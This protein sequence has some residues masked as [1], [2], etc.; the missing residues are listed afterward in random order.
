MVGDDSMYESFDNFQ[1]IIAQSQFIEDWTYDPVTSQSVYYAQIDVDTFSLEYAWGVD[2]TV[3][4]VDTMD[5]SIQLPI[6]TESRFSIYP[7][8]INDYVTLN[9]KTIGNQPLKIRVFNTL[10]N[11]VYFKQIDFSDSSLNTIQTADWPTGMYT[12]IIE[13]GG[14]NYYQKL[15]KF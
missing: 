14:K 2:S 12:V 4:S 11:E 10:G 13:S 7:N 9:L 15:I 6:H 8:P 3:T 5:T 1:N